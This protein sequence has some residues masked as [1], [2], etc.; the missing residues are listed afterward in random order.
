M[1]SSAWMVVGFNCIDI[2]LVVKVDEDLQV[3]NVA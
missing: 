2:L 1:S 3:M